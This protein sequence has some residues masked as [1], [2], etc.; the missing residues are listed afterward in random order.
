M[1]GKAT[2][3]DNNLMQTTA[4]D[5]ENGFIQK[6]NVENNVI[7]KRENIDTSIITGTIG[8]I[9]SILLIPFMG[10][11]LIYHY[12]AWRDS[13]RK[14][15]ES[16]TDKNLFFILLIFLIFLITLTVLLIPS[17]LLSLKVF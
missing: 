1:I 14:N 9:L 13:I 11:L 15:A 3:T 7:A 4:S 17:P 16:K 2:G 12:Q 10:K 6:E 5:Y 8:L